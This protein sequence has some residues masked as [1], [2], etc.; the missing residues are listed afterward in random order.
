M[1][2]TKK[3]LDT[4][5]IIIGIALIIGFFEVSSYSYAFSEKDVSEKTT[6][7]TPR[8]VSNAK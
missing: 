3:T 4:F 1:K 8:L 2:F 5:A 6:T 7:I